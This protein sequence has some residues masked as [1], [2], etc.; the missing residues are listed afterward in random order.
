MSAYSYDIEYEGTKLHA[1]ADSV[2][3]LPVQGEEDQDT[4]ATAM[5]K[6]SLIEDLPMTATDIAVLSQ[7]Y[8]FVLER[9]PQRGVGDG[10]KPFCQCKDH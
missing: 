6:I 9:W 1:N 2:S 10:V 7:V 4:A 3:H 5:F 8:Q